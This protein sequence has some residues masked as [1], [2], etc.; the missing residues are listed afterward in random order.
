MWDAQ[1]GTCG[2]CR[3]PLP[4]NKGPAIDHD[5]ETG[6]VRGLLCLLCNTKLDWALRHRGAIDEYLNQT[7]LPKT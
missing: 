3:R 6:Y 7:K 4:G 5:H 2:I 1:G